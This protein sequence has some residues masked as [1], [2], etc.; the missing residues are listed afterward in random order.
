[1]EPNA[2]TRQTEI[3]GAMEDL[4]GEVER[5]NKS[6]ESLATRIGPVVNMNPT[7]ENPAKE[8]TAIQ[9]MGSEL[10]KRIQDITVKVT[11]MR[12]GIKYLTERIEL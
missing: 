1:M 3:S 2:P 11:Q 5:L 4:Q 7:P 10:A 6:I 8:P 9:T 12:N